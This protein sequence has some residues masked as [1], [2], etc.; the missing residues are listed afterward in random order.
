MCS[1]R[2]GLTTVSRISLVKPQKSQAV[3]DILLQMTRFGQVRQR[4]T[5]DQLISLLDQVERSSAE[6]AGKITVRA[7]S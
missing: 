1:G 4:V 3:T 6:P 7:L 2:A 5:E